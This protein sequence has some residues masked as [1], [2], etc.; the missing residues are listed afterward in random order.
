MATYIL[1]PLIHTIARAFFHAGGLGLLTLGI[2]DS[3]LLVLPVGNDLLVL[4]LCARYPQRV[5][6]YVAMATLGSVIGS[7][8]TDW[9]GRKSEGKLKKYVA[10]KHMKYLRDWVEKR[11]ALTLVVA[12]LLPPPFPFTA[13]VAAAAAFRYPRVKLLS[14]VAAGRFLRFGIEGAL[15]VHYGHWIVG[16]AKSPLLEHVMVAIIVLSIIGTGYSIYRRVTG[17]KSAVVRAA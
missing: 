7:F 15:A 13:I 6:Y 5:L 10:G 2:L 17:N 11:A 16:Q 8:T 14:F 12:S 1:K 3:S 9:A 4:A